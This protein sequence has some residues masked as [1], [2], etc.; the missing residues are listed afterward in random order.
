M[1]KGFVLL[2]ALVLAISGASAL[3]EMGVYTAE[4][5][6]FH[7]VVADGVPA[8]L[9][10]ME[11]I[12]GGIAVGIFGA[13][14][15]PN[16]FAVRAGIN[17]AFD[18]ALAAGFFQGG[19]AGL[20]GGMSYTDAAGNAIT[21]TANDA[22]G[23]E[24]LYYG[25]KTYEGNI[26]CGE[27]ESNL[28]TPHGYGIVKFGSGLINAGVWVDGLMQGYGVTLR[29]DGS[30]FVGTFV[31]GRLNGY[32]YFFTAEGKC[33]LYRYE[34]DKAVE[35]LNN[36]EAL[37]REQMALSPDELAAT[38]TQEET[39]EADVETEA[40]AK[41]EPTPDA[42]GADSSGDTVSDFFDAL[43]PDGD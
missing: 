10:Y 8:G 20:V 35:Q 25:T 17:P 29:A 41:T 36:G 24:M 39:A 14:G 33:Y 19:Y 27:M 28:S 34:S 30:G 37:T 3:A 16:G 13:N 42:A 43:T 32:T 40:D 4:D 1:K 31:D 23:T 6:I 38:M 5:G 2:V 21:F 22:R 9:G 18:Y 26:Y 12:D 7:G 15:E 11:Y